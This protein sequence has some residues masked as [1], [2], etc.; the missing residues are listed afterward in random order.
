MRGCLLGLLVTVFCL[1]DLEGECRDVLRN[2]VEL[3][4]LILEAS[5]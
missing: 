3:H 1:R 2:G 4:R 5:S